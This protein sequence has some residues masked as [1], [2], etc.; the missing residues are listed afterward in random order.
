M[1]P[2]TPDQR[3][4][5]L[6]GGLLDAPGQSIEILNVRTVATPNVTYLGAFTVWPRDRDSSSDTDLGFPAEQARVIHPAFGVVIPANETAFRHPDETTAS[7][8]SVQVGFRLQSGM[9]GAIN[10]VEVEYRA[11]SEVKRARSGAGAILCLTPCTEAKAHDNVLAWERSLREQLGTVVSDTPA[12]PPVS[13]A[14]P[15]KASRPGR[16]RP[17]SGAP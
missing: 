7:P 2:L 1:A 17:S 16:R 4:I 3:D 5:T 10:D 8:V 6:N 14:R 9:Y 12:L 11:D 13:S 15:T